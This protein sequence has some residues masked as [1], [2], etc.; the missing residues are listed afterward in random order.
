MQRIAVIGC[1]G[2]GKSTLARQIG[3]AL[4]LPVFHLDRLWW[5]DGSYRIRGAKTVAAHTMAATDFR[6]LQQELA[7]ADAWVIDGGY[8]PDLDTRLARADTVVFLDLPRRVCLWRLARRHNRRRPDYPDQVREGL[9]WFLLLVRWIHR[10]PTEKRPAIEQA[11]D[12][13]C[14]ADTKILR[15]RRR[16]DVDRLLESIQG[17]PPVVTAT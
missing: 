3:A 4:S 10:Y 11:I 1:I 2:A 8:I 7:A 17:G 13:H 12:A 6:R 14:P 16:R 5:Q 9:G 15:L